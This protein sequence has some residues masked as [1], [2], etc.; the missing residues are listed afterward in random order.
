[1]GGGRYAVG[2]GSW[3]VALVLRGGG[4]HIN[5]DQNPAHRSSPTDRWDWLHCER[6]VRNNGNDVMPFDW[7]ELVSIK[8]TNYFF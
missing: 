5:T 6:S 2:G 3:L 1:M 7:M 8:K 4:V